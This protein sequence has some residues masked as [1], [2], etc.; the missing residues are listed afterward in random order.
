LLIVGVVV[1]QM[2]QRLNT[3]LLN[4]TPKCRFTECMLYQISDEP[5]SDIGID[6]LV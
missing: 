5:I 6:F 2:M 1:F 4:I 3:A